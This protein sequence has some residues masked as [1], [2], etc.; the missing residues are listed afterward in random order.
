[1]NPVL[2]NNMIIEFRA[3][4]KEA[5]A[6]DQ[7]DLEAASNKSYSAQDWAEFLQEPDIRDYIKREMRVIRE[8]SINKI[9]ADAGTSRSVGQAQLI[10]ALQKVADDDKEADGPVFIYCYVP[11]NDQ[12]MHAPNVQEVDRFDF[13]KKPEA[14]P[15]G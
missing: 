9:I 2:K 5:L 15:E 3:L 8:S 4:G 12:Q 1:M 13:P 7:Y 14:L 10:S 11:L 6:M